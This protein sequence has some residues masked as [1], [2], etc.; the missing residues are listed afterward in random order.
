VERFLAERL[1]LR[2]NNK[3]QSLQPVSN[4]VNFLGYIV[5]RDYLL[6]RRRVANN[7]KARLSDF[8]RKLIQK[9]RSPYAK[10]VYDYPTL[11]KLRATLAS[12]FGHFKWADSY[13]LKM[14]LMERYGFLKRFF[15]LKNGRIKEHYS[16]PG[17]IPSIR[18]QYR[19]FKTRFSEDILLFQ[20]GSYYEF[21]EDESDTAEML[22]LRRI[23]KP[24]ARNVKYGFPVRLEAV[25]IEKIK[26]CGRSVT[27]EGEEDRY[28]TRV[29]LRLPKYSLVFQR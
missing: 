22:G 8:E 9:D 25:F 3:R 2:L 24:F 20:V 26:G 1:K 4:G 12:Y 16:V 11:E 17:N 5:R 19:Y 7:L 29:K 18:L 15:K 6:V 13:R 21:Y 27:V 10:V 23:H 28:M 14:S